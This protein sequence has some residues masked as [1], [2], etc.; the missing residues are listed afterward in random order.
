MR[1]KP[2][3][4]VPVT[5]IYWCDVCKRPASFTEGEEFP[6]CPSRCGRC[7][8]KLVREAKLEEESKPA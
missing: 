6:P 2:G 8:W 3:A 5:G 1:H 4:R 7:L